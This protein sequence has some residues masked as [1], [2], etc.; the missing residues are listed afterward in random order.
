M[1]KDLMIGRAGLAVVGEPIAEYLRGL[2]TKDR[3]DEW[4]AANDQVAVISLL[5]LASVVVFLQ[6]VARLDGFS[7]EQDA[8][9]AFESGTT[10]FKN[11]PW[12]DNSIWLPVE[13]EAPKSFE[14]DDPTFIGSAPALLRELRTLQ[15]ASPLDLGRAPNGYEQMRADIGQFYRSDNEEQLDE[16]AI[17]QWIWRALHDGAELA[18]QARTV[19][20]A[21]PG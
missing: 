6:H 16:P 19:L 20:W 10:S 15:E 11:M 12:W 17:I 1:G 13:I 4:L 21:A 5:N 7:S 8:F 2:G 3:L 18:I 9:A 14:G